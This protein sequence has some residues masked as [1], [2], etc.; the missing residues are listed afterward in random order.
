MLIPNK[1][2]SMMLL[3][4]CA[5]C[6]DIYVAREGQGEAAECLVMH[7]PGTCC[8]YEEKRIS[9]RTVRKAW[10]VVDGARGV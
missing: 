9:I 6:E 10:K 4:K 8:H 3:Y 5:A 2:E 7:A 1:D